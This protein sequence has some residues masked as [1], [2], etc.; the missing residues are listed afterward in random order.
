MELG[1]NAGY[2]MMLRLSGL[3]ALVL[4]TTGGCTLDKGPGVSL[5]IHLAGR[6][7]TV[8]GSLPGS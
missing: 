7:E 2:W 6:D 5:V 8:G 4:S 3:P 1:K